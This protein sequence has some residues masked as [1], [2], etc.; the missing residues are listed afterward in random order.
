M[1]AK[2]GN[3]FGHFSGVFELWTVLLVVLGTVVENAKH[4]KVAPGNSLNLQKKTLASIFRS[5]KFVLPKCTF[6]GPQL[7]RRGLVWYLIN[8]SKAHAP[9]E[10]DNTYYCDY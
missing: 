6:L 4:K 8:S 3:G 2:W 7:S 5:L 9:R 1:C 10:L